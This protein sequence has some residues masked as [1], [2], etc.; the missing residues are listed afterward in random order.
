MSIS[1]LSDVFETIQ[2]AQSAVDFRDFT[3]KDVK[4]LELQMM[5]RL[6]KH[7]RKRLKSPLNDRL[8]LL[9]F[10]GNILKIGR[11]IKLFYFMQDL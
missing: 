8:I 9:S 11:T 3:N 4:S 2:L 1:F 7:Y 6:N 10:D 5:M